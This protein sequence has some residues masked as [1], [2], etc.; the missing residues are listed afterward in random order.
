R[1]S[2]KIALYNAYGRKN[3]FTINFN[4]IIDDSGALK[5]PSDRSEEPLL[6]SSMMYVHGA[7]PSITYHFNF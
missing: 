3:P 5:I 1:H 2:L 4:K 6:Q 7:V